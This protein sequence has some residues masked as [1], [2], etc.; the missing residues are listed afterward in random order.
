MSATPQYAGDPLAQ[1]R[2][3]A[4]KR[5]FAQFDPVVLSKLVLIPA[6]TDAL[7]DAVGLW[8]PRTGRDAL[9]TLE[10]ADIVERRLVSAPG[11]RSQEE[12]WVRERARNALAGFLHDVTRLERDLDQLVGAV[13]SLDTGAFGITA[14]FEV[15]SRYRQDSSGVS[16][17]KAVDNLVA[18]GRLA[19]ATDLVGAARVLG[20]VTGGPL[21]DASRRAGWHIERAYRADVDN[22]A[23]RCY[24]NRA[25]PESALDELIGASPSWALHFL[26]GG[27]VG[28]TMLIRYL[29]SG[30][31]A[32]D[33][34]MPMFPVARA[35]FDYLDPRYPQERP[36]E[37]LLALAHELVS[38][39]DTRAVYQ[40]YRRFQDAA[41]HLHEESARS[42]LDDG[43]LRQ[44]QERVVGQFARVVA[45]AADPGKPVVLILDT[46]EELAK[47]YPPG[48]RAPAIDRT[49]GLLEQLREQAPA[50]RVLLAGRRWL[51]PAADD[52]TRA[53]G[54]KLLQRPYL[55]VLHLA[56]L[57]ADAAA[58]YVD[59]RA[60][61]AASGRPGGPGRPGRP[62]PELRD[63]I[64]DRAR[65]PD[66]SGRYNPFELA[67]YCEWA[68]SDT[69]P[70]AAELRDAP[71]DPYVE[72]RIIGRIMDDTVRQALPIA[73]EFGRFDVELLRPALIRVGIDADKA[74]AGL[75][76]QEWTR[77]LTITA[78]GLPGVIEVDEH[79]RDRIR[80]ALVK[81]NAYAV[82]DP[83]HLGRDA[84]ALL[85]SGP[86]R[87][88]PAEAVEAAVRLLPVD[89]AAAMWDK[90]EEK[91]V[92][93]SAWP[94]AETVTVRAGAVELQR[95]G[96]ENIIAAILATQAA[97]RIHA[98]I[99]EGLADLWLQ[100]I[101]A[102]N[103]YPAPGGAWLYLRGILGLSAVGMPSIVSDSEA[104]W[105][106]DQ[107]A[108][109]RADL[110]P[111]VAAL[112]G[113]IGSGERRL[114]PANIR[115]AAQA[116]L[117]AADANDVSRAGLALALATL[118]LREG[119]LDEAA[120]LADAALTAATRATELSGPGQ[121]RDCAD[122]RPP[123]GLADRC[124]L[125]VLLIACRRGDPSGE[126]R[127]WDW[128]RSVLDRP[129]DAD[130]QRL[131]AFAVQY[132]LGH[133]PVSAEILTSLDID[134][135]PARALT[136]LHRQGGSLAAAL[137][138]GWLVLGDPDRAARL[139]RTARDR[140]VELVG[141]DPETIEELQLALLSLCRRCRSQEYAPVLQLCYNGTPAVRAE[142]WLV[143]TLLT[144]DRPQ[145]PAE[146][147]SWHGWWR[148]QD[149][150]TGASRLPAP[151]D[152][153][154]GISA[155]DSAGD[156]A[157]FAALPGLSAVP[158]A[159]EAPPLS[160]SAARQ[161]LIGNQRPPADLPAGMVGRAMLAAAEVLALRVPDVAVARLFDCAALLKD[162]GD[163]AGASQAIVLADLAR[164]RTDHPIDDA[165]RPASV[166]REIAIMS[167][168]PQ[169]R[170]WWDYITTWRVVTGQ[171]QGPPVDSLSPELDVG[172]A[173][174]GPTVSRWRRWLPR[175]TG[176]QL[177]P[178]AG[179]ALSLAALAVALPLSRA[180]AAVSFIV[181]YATLSG[182]L[183]F[184]VARD[185]YGYA[186]GI[187]RAITIRPAGEG[188]A[189]LT[190]R[191]FGGLAELESG[192]GFDAWVSRTMSGRFDWSADISVDSLEPLH[193]RTLFHPVNWISGYLAV[194]LQVDPRLE[195]Y[196]WE[197]R[198]GAAF[199]RWK[200]R[201][202]VF[203]RTVPGYPPSANRRKWAS[204]PAVYMGPRAL[205]PP[206]PVTPRLANNGDS[207]VRQYR[208]VMY[209]VGT[210]VSTSAGWRMRVSPGAS[211][212]TVE[213]ARGT[214]S[215]EELVS[216]DSLGLGGTWLVVL[217][218][219][220]L[221]GP[222]AVLGDLAP[223]FRALAREAVEA[224]AAVAIVVPTLPDQEAAK[225]V[226]TTWSRY[227][228]RPVLMPI[229]RFVLAGKAKNLC[230]VENPPDGEQPALDVLVYARSAPRR[231][232]S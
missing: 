26:G 115:R 5:M 33:R 215:G 83:V 185:A 160:E 124:R 139:L 148:C 15:V 119:R 203:V 208:R 64:L 122:W 174:A 29:A 50:V 16:L 189:V 182:W 226:A 20:E 67:S 198:L 99:A 72:L 224:G 134:A 10:Q 191:P 74:F 86:L 45:E 13:A 117:R 218:A 192:G 32:A 143:R 40:F 89:E 209:L 184:I 7:A 44:L 190:G 70:D 19:V 116:A 223:G 179:L 156:H 217:Q 61:R 166:R 69:P 43:L 21:A 109:H 92:A 232:E 98:G 79:L 167:E 25:E 180:A 12:F 172:F 181:V 149:A 57:P 153:E 51:T 161:W 197:R 27:G 23:L 229:R 130:A 175:V 17:I 3:E 196:P 85:E 4:Q 58:S 95:P 173:T 128:R 201:R 126:D 204:A 132:E 63:A 107:P 91:I 36:A 62:D 82:G 22:Q 199:S 47:L 108:F 9:Q 102:V 53:A 60:A 146:A 140:V 105:L 110:G 151:P 193:V 76:A 200:T 230:Y 75:A 195:A 228:R 210:P 163:L 219:E 78:E 120:E 227:A 136:W 111:L 137:A 194:V 159:P 73:V 112:D 118:A 39:G 142:A 24:V 100:V 114:P 52:A 123:P 206:K 222:P 54:P 55:R 133:H 14:W 205:A 6:W 30:R 34:G 88:V 147:G 131:A 141:D 81:S 168:S 225:M 158:A 37:L 77:A 93:E 18:T 106:L 187:P 71:G 125:A 170:G 145:S 188:R 138:E 162:A 144:G 1:L 202:A 11:G 56:G 221:N 176:R 48:S 127:V 129:R 87:D 214:V 171:L 96:E 186:A 169:W 84:A 59:L 65:E 80:K 66:G 154:P 177:L 231:K 41:N 103:G 49:F 178:Y 213:S 35:D 155:L 113:P 164:A 150:R 121:V 38:F 216:V 165:E 28:K 8:T 220:P 68:Y 212:K 211:A 152:S 104:S 46:C 101:A 90:L 94:W 183:S 2:A 97:A 31:Y 135:P 207:R 157:E 42:D